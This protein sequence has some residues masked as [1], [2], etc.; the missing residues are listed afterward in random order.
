MQVL[1]EKMLSE[2]VKRGR[3]SE[4]LEVSRQARLEAIRYFEGIRA[5]LD[6]ARRVPDS[7]TWHD[8]LEP[9]LDS[10][11]T[12][13]DG[14]RESERQLLAIVTERLQ[15]AE[16]TSTREKLYRLKQT[17][18][19]EY[20]IHAQL[21]TLIGDAGARYLRSQSA[22]F[23][24]RSRQSL[25][26]LD[27]RVLPDLAQISVSSLASIADSESFG[28]FSAVPPRLL[29]LPQFFDLLL[30]PQP[31]ELAHDEVEDELIDITEIPPQFSPADIRAAEKFLRESFADNP[32]TDIEKILANAEA[33][34]LARPVQE[35]MTFVMY[36]CFA[37]KESPFAIDVAVNGRF[38]SR[39][40]EGGRLEFVLR[41]NPNE[42]R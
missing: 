16:D 11:R 23:R 39:V 2:L 24:A 12:H 22:L 40:V 3:V 13:I 15:E 38:R 18:D 21:L 36:Q 6:R 20:D 33:A 1:M 41:P 32:K 42:P 28:L 35:Y 29:Y 19:S 10:S 25:P 37:Q 30:E 17:V 27:D 9:F 14:R 31:E 8:D 4:A 7:V 34:G 5:H 26:N